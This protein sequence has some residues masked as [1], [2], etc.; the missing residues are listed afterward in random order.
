M[1]TLIIVDIVLYSVRRIVMRHRPTGNTSHKNNSILLRG[2][3]WMLEEVLSR[4]CAY[5]DI[6]RPLR[7]RFMFVSLAQDQIKSR[8][9]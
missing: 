3:K 9:V 6:E 4:Y 5:R 2:K 8:K 1:V 7:I